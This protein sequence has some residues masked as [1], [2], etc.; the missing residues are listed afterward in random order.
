MDK[1]LEMRKRILHMRVTNPCMCNF[2]IAKIC[3]VN[4]RT[5]KR[6]LQRFN[7]DRTVERNVGSGRK[8]GPAD[9]C[10][11]KK[12]VKH[13]MNH[14]SESGRDIAKRF[15]IAESTVRKIKSRNGMKTYKKQKVPKH[16]EKQKSTIKPKARKLY[17]LILE[18]DCCVIVDDE[19]YVKM[20]FKTL[21]GPQFFTSFFQE[22]QIQQQRLQSTSLGL[23]CLFGR[24]SVNAASGAKHSSLLVRQTKIYTS[25]NAC[26]SAFCLSFKP[27][28]AEFCFGQ[29]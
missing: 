16:T 29:T 9:P 20:D 13:I 2:Q 22:D 10:L 19:T 8:V 6:V 15:G 11:E 25:M 7:Q 5:V 21:P 24:P 17:E 18:K 4:Q 12:I 27:T 26:R 28:R 14:R 3:K 1:Q 23:K